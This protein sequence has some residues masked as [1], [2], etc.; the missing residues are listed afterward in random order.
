MKNTSKVQK[1]NEYNES[2][3][4]SILKAKQ[5]DKSNQRKNIKK[6]TDDTKKASKR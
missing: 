2:K 3:G 5:H 1:K 6:L 4:K